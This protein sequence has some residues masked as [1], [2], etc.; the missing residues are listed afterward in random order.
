MV[1]AW[2]I[3][4][5]VLT[6]VLMLGVTI[7]VFYLYC[8]P[9]DNTFVL[10]WVAKL[11]VIAAFAVI[12]GFI[13]LLPLDVANSRGL[14]GGLN[15]DL[16]YQLMFIIVFCFVGFILPYTLFLYETDD[17]KPFIARIF[18]ALGY[19]AGIT[20]GIACFALISW[21]ALRKAHMGDLVR[22]DLSNLMLSSATG[23]AFTTQ[24]IKNGVAYNLPPYLFMCVFII[25]VGWFFFVLFGGIGIIALPFDLI[26]GYVYRPKPRPALEMAEKKVALRRRCEE[27]ISFTKNVE[28]TMLDSEEGGNIFSKWRAGRK[29][30][31]NE[32]KLQKELYLLEQEIE[33]YE[34]ESELKA[35]PL[36]DI[37]KLVLGTFL[38]IISL[39]IIL[40]MLLYNII[41]IKGRPASLF[42]NSF[43]YWVEYKIASFISTIFFAAFGVYLVFCVMKG[44]IRFGLRLFFI[45]KIHPMQL[46][47][48]YM[49]SFLFNAIMIMLASLGSIHFTILLFRHY[50]RLT[51]GTV[52]FGTLLTRLR[53]LKAFWQYKVFLY[54]FLLFSVAACGLVIWKPKADK[55]DVREM[56]NKRKKK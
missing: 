8:H 56:I 55:L 1:S 45:I 54:L 37:A 53:V 48:T 43:L 40:H 27:L 23:G 32:G 41:V 4:I 47:K 16:A 33:I 3:V 51:S 26:M 36:W 46:N 35:N 2:L 7:Y 6:A 39:I 19:Q 38:A 25:F 29:V 14:G 22:A 50:M 13:L 20:F 12:W 52:V 21:G 28:G 17:E 5:T 31:N 34:L 42:L 24:I 30:K 44:A 11:V 18:I 15:M 9:D 49:N 10:A